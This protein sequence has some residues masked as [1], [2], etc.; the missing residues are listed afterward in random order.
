[1]DGYAVFDTECT[2]FS[3]AKGS[4]MIEI[5]VVLVDPM[6]NIEYDWDALVN[7]HGPV[8]ATD[9]HGITADMVREASDFT[10]IAGNISE[11]FS[12]RVVVAHNLSF[13]KRFIDHH[14][15]EIGH[16][17]NLTGF[18]T[19]QYAKKNLGLKSNTLSSVCQHLGISLD[20]A[21][22]ALDD[23]RATAMVLSEFLDGAR[24][25]GATPIQWPSLDVSD[26]IHLSRGTL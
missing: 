8:G 19:M 1:M 12:N 24:H 20:N 6:G 10:E 5:A 13:D 25:S 9:I 17:T 15:T 22:C 3:P 26:K 21:H 2:G 23:T 4:R 18:C 7:P 16:P 14:F 11:L